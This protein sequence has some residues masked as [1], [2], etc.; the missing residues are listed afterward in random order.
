MR[1]LKVGSDVE[2]K[3]L[4][5]FVVKLGCGASTGLRGLSLGMNMF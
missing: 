1:P 3:Q 4:E 5:L 2:A